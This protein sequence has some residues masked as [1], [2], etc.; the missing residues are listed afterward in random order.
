MNL[1]PWVVYLHLLGVVA[2]VLAHGTSVMV[3]LQLRGERQPARVRALLDLS[4][5]SIRVMYIALLILL[6]GGVAAA[7][8]GGYWGR[9]WIWASIVVLVAVLGL[10]YARATSYY[11]RVRAAVGIRP[12]NAPKDA[13]DP[14]PLPAS[15]VDALLSGGRAFELVGIGGL[16]LMVIVWLMV[17]KPF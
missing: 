8:G 9:L 5:G 3:A 2:F 15:E 4:G 11:A 17:A 13:P 16:G 1:Y 14:V 6:V 7:F 10:M 12:Y